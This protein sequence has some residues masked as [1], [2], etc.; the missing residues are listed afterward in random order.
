MDLQN[1]DESTFLQ[2]C[3]EFPLLLAVACTSKQVASCMCA[4][5]NQ[6]A[7]IMARASPAPATQILTFDTISQMFSQEARSA[8]AAYPVYV[9]IT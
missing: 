8:L 6:Q 9:V 1:R 3:L 2:C 4:N 5:E 7:V